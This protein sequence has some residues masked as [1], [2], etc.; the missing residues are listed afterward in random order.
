METALK[1]LESATNFATLGNTED[2]KK[3]TKTLIVTTGRVDITTQR[4]DLATQD[5]HSSVKEGFLQVTELQTQLADNFAK[6]M[7]TQ[8]EE[9]AVCSLISVWIHDIDYAY[10]F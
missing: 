8:K 3:D 1:R 9:A 7:Q 2:I 5:I 6:M 4:I 10:I